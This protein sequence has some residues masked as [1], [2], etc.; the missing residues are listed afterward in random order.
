MQIKV[1]EIKRIC[2]NQKNYSLGVRYYNERDVTTMNIIYSDEFH[3]YTIDA[4]LLHYTYRNHSE[5]VINEEGRILS[6][7]CNCS[8]CSQDFA[9][10]HVVAVLYL[11]MEQEPRIFPFY[12][13]VHNLNRYQRQQQEYA[14]NAAQKEERIIIDEQIEERKNYLEQLRIKR[15]E[16]YRK[17]ELER[18][19]EEQ[20]RKRETSRML[21]VSEKS[22]LLQSIPLISAGN[23]HIHVTFEDIQNKYYDVEHSLSISLRVGN[24]KMYVIN[25]FRD[26]Y[27]AYQNQT[28]HRYGKNLAFVHGP[29]AFDEQSNAIIQILLHNYERSYRGGEHCGRK[30]DVYGSYIDELFDLLCPLEDNTCVQE[31]YAIRIGVEKIKDDYRVSLISPKRMNKIM[32]GEYHF[33]TLENGVLTRKGLDD[34]GIVMRL[35]REIE[36]DDLLIDQQDIHAFCQYVLDPCMEHLN[37]KGKQALPEVVK[38]TLIQLY[39]DVDEEGMVHITLDCY[40][41]DVV[42]PGFMEEPPQTSSQI[43]LVENYIKQYADIVDYGAHQ[44]SMDGDS[45]ETILFLQDGMVQ[46]SQYCEIYI[47]DALKRKN[48]LNAL[49][50]QVGVKIEN[51]LLK[52][53]VNSVDISAEEINDV[54]KAYRK[55]KRYYRL[56]NG[57]LINLESDE[58]RDVD[59]M[60][61]DMN[62]SYQDMKQGG[63]QVP[64]YRGFYM[65]DI[66]D[67]DSSLAF[68][69]DFSYESFMDK[70]LEAQDDV[71]LPFSYVDILRDYQKEGFYWLKKLQAF[72]FGGIL[73]DDMGLGKT[74][75]VIALLEHEQSDDRTSIVIAPS[76]LLLNWKDE[77]AKFSS[78]L[79]CCVV[80]GNAQE[81]KAQLLSYKAYDVMI[82]SY[83]YMRR[84]YEEYQ[85]HT[86]FYVILD[87]AQYIKNQKTK[88]AM[89]VKQLQAKHKLA[90]TGTPIENSL[91]ELWSLFDFL[92]PGY[93]YNYHYFQTHFEKDIVNTHNEDKQRVLK[94]MVTPFILRR[95]KR[96]VLKELPD[97]IETSLTLS[98]S[99]EEHKLYLAHLSKVNKELQQKL[100]LEKLSKPIVLSMLTRLRQICCEPRILFENVE[101]VG[102][103]MK[104]C[105]ELISSLRENHQ[106]IL[107]FSSFTSVLDLL[108]QELTKAHIR[109]LLLTGQTNKQERHE[110]VEKFQNGVGDIFLISLKAG[111]TG[112]NLT[113]AQAVIHYD[114]W[115]NASAQNQAT[116]RA[117][118]IG[119][120]EQVSVYK[121]IMED[122]IEKKI[123]ELQE[124]KKNLADS[125]VE[126]ND[127]IIQTMSMDEI[128]DLFN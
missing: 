128:M 83:D 94:K 58:L 84:D 47:S 105:M 79:K 107:L 24:K 19:V 9:C 77:I 69:K 22:K 70:Y 27:N 56:K 108:A 29:K 2:R 39:A 33:Y 102:S 14:I 87:E 114:P 35:F 80:M 44:A 17:Y 36:S 92:M 109:Y 51:D 32:S 1:E 81:R 82:T 25:N 61:E 11:L 113:A 16:L 86:F 31:S 112:L 65:Q 55:K 124:K 48:H 13:D 43:E 116:D 78:T 41:D 57:D 8:F 3:T 118:R 53:D 125:F 60:M 104:G 88:N 120:S 95:N 52:I 64:L 21:I 66:M 7:G 40:F 115:W 54:L 5:I 93:L 98:F 110:L 89:S 12:Y 73:A 72:H 62:L 123:Q 45:E 6:Y 100:E 4:N 18:Q 30:I 28:L 91:A 10:A 63:M 49:D 122:S 106:R 37:I 68:R 67:Q 127:G 126:G 59:H 119:Q 97:K 26:F 34:T 20:N 121:L 85:H 71:Q 42:V 99:D 75:Q 23:Y 96:D 46:L 76:S 101:E 50:I 90:L 117:H 15:E 103:K 111:G 74:L 38:E